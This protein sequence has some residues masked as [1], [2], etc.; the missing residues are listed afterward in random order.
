MMVRH[1]NARRDEKSGSRPASRSAQEVCAGSANETCRPARRGADIEKGRRQKIRLADD[2]F[3]TAPAGSRLSDLL[4]SQSAPQEE[5]IGTSDLRSRRYG[6]LRW[7]W[8]F[9][10]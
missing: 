6:I 5:I 3:E 8:L 7:S 2:D 10:P 1:Q 4:R 9:D